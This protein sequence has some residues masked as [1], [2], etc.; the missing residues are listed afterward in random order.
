VLPSTE[1]VQNTTPVEDTVSEATLSV[2]E[3]E[4]QSEIDK[5]NSGVKASVTVEPI[6]EKEEKPGSP[7]AEKKSPGGEKSRRNGSIFFRN[8]FRNSYTEEPATVWIRCEWN[9]DEAKES[10]QLNLRFEKWTEE[11]SK[12]GRVNPNSG[13]RQSLFR[14]RGWRPR[15]ESEMNDL[16]RNQHP[17]SASI[18]SDNS[19]EEENPAE[20][21]RPKERSGFCFGWGSSGVLNDDDEA[22]TMSDGTLMTE[23]PPGLVGLVNLGNTC[24]LNTAL[25]CLRCTPGLPSLVIPELSNGFEGV[26]IKQAFADAGKGPLLPTQLSRYR[27]RRLQNRSHSSS[28]MLPE[29]L[30]LEWDC[31][32]AARSNS[33]PTPLPYEI[34]GRLE[35]TGLAGGSVHRLSSVPNLFMREETSTAPNNTPLSHV[36]LAAVPTNEDLIGCIKNKSSADQDEISQRDDVDV[37]GQINETQELPEGM[38]A[39]VL[40]HSLS[41]ASFDPAKTRDYS[42]EKKP[43]EEDSTQ[44][45][46]NNDQPLPESTSQ[47]TDGQDDGKETDRT[48][49]EEEDSE[50]E[51]SPDFISAFQKLV[52]ELCLGE[53]DNHRSPKDLYLQLKKLPQGEWFCDGGQHDCQEIFKVLLDTIHANYTDFPRD[54]EGGKIF[55]RCISDVSSEIQDSLAAIE[56]ENLKANSMWRRYISSDYSPITDVFAG[57]L[58]IVRSCQK[59]HCRSTTYE[60][61]WDLSLSLSRE[62]SSWFNPGRMPSS[63][64]DLLRAFTAAEVLQ[65]DEAPFC[66]CCNQKSPATRRILIHRF[67]KVLVFNIKRFKYT[68]DGR[69]KLTANI[70]FPV[71]S[72]RLQNFASKEHQ[73]ESI[74]ELYDLYAVSNHYGTLGGGHYV[75][76]C[77]VKDQEAKEGWYCFNDKVVTKIAEESLVTPN[78]YILF[79]AKRQ[80]SESLSN[81]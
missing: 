51:L 67:P 81:D 73:H 72:L 65:G 77:K 17:S 71:R 42:K 60:P 12:S 40:D 54:H 21:T 41:D 5:N 62:R 27:L 57:Q 2:Q 76:Y 28:S 31:T 22:I 25:Q 15:E 80:F 70:T 39:K 74:T 3:D 69:E 23:A 29:R 7:I 34:G 1:F 64:D 52:L 55:G 59:C 18:K 35:G 78:A 75:A 11:V 58:Q 53:V 6:K 50:V 79:Y 43:P 49:K 10:V 63:L 38:N 47:I 33:L 56:V 19:D 44:S 37:K 14:I 9:F 66:E 68:K 45:H 48:T 4:K 30:H 24:F 32:V 26:V 46:K 61:F 20:T 13:S 36:N 16:V 8:F